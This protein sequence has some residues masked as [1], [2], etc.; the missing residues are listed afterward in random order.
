MDGFMMTKQTIHQASS[1][2]P[3]TPGFRRDPLGGC[4][5]AA[6]NE[7]RYDL[8]RELDYRIERHRKAGKDPLDLFDPSKP[9]Y[10]GKPE[11]MEFHRRTTLRRAL[12]NRADQVEAAAMASAEKFRRHATLAELERARHALSNSADHREVIARF[13]AH[14]INFS[15]L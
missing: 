10:V 14:G 15:A 2:E 6:W 3:G 12:E 7:T 11:A 8:E 5:E 13:K 4:G 9:D 1:N